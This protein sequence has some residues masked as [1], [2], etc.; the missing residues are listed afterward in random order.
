MNTKINSKYLYTLIVILIILAVL[1][2]YILIKSKERVFPK[3]KEYREIKI[4]MTQNEVENRLGQPYK[5]YLKDSAPEDYY[6]DGYSYNKRDITNKLYIYIDGE[7]IAYIY[8]DNYNKVEY[9]YVGG[10]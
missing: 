10:S 4:G 5:V 9:V 8:F 2:I 1:L 6:I 7:P 3:Y